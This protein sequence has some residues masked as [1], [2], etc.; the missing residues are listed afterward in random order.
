MTSTPA[1]RPLRL[2]NTVTG[3]WDLVGDPRLTTHLNDPNGHPLYLTEAEA[4]ALYLPADYEP[5]PV[6]PE[7]VDET[8]LATALAAYQPTSE[9]GQADGYAPLDAGGKLPSAHL[10]PLAIT[11]TF[12]VSGEAAMLALPA[13]VGDVC[14]RT[15]TGASLI[16]AAAP[17]STLANWVALGGAGGGVTSVDGQTGA[18][19]LSASYVNTTGD[20]TMA[21][22]LTAANYVTP[23]FLRLGPGGDTTLERLT[24]GLLQV[25]GKMLLDTTE[26]DGRYVTRALADAKGD[27]FA[28]SGPDAVGRL[29]LGTDGQVLTADGT[30]TLGVKWADA[31][32][33]AGSYLP[34]AG[35]TLTGD[36]VVSEATPT[37]SLKLTADTQPRSRLSD[38]ALAFGPGGV[39][40]LDTHIIRDASQSLLI[41]GSLA[42][43]SDVAFN[44]GRSNR[45]WLTTHTQ[46]LSTSNPPF[47]TA[48]AGS[49]RLSNNTAVAWRNA[50][51]S[52]DLSL[53]VDGSDRF[54]FTGDVLVSEATPTVSLKQ[55]SDTQPRSQLSDTALAFGP[56]G[57]TAPDVTLQRTGAGALRLD[58]HLGVGVAP[59]AWGP[60]QRA[61]QLGQ[62]AAV[63]GA[64]DSPTTFFKA[65][66]YYD[67][68]ANRAV[69]AGPAATM[70]FGGAAGVYTVNTAPSVAA[71][72]SQAFTT[73]LYLANN[74][75]L[76]VSPDAGVP[77]VVF[78]NGTLGV[79]N[80]T[81]PRV[82]STGGQH[83][84]L[85]GNSGYVTPNGDGGNNLGNPSVRWGTVYASV[86]TINTSS[87]E[88]K[89][90]ISPLD[91]AAAMQAV[92][93][94]VPVTFD[95]KPPERDAAWYELPD[96]P[97]QAEQVL[98]QRLTAAP[99]EAG[100]RH[101]AGFVLGSSEYPTD[102]LFET[103]EGQSNAANSVGILLAAVQSIDQRLTALEGA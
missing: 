59:A 8:E 97:D 98:L 70:D 11:E 14:V 86:G 52:A 90:A 58:T 72:A 60:N 16:L 66:S 74:G 40:S 42:P 63:A 65:N 31:A 88:A 53:S 6:P 103:G 37:V 50:A 100:A 49:V 13:Q 33:G 96:D 75:G 44:L 92:R 27:L 2:W 64:T 56:G 91:P 78:G 30:Q 32:G 62:A 36:L 5:P 80:G 4:N 38:T 76:T 1:S 87:R 89:E 51:N 46:V 21:G 82:S 45:R 69:V 43:N 93:G 48:T 28:A 67:G 25:N 15:D 39:A 79:G 99:L 61:L 102:P 29:P 22:S 23:G 85:Y 26:G 19:D 81:A 84:E 95:Y 20:D 35:G 57:T 68:S 83:L 77:A 94:T 10:P 7:Y 55:A 101:Q 41:N 24:T 71:G 34:L 54:A 17:A 12:V 18:V 73:R 3:Q 47:A 9:R